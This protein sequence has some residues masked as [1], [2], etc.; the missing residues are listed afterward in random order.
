MDWPNIRSIGFIACPDSFCSGKHIK[1]NHRNTKKPW[2]K[3]RKLWAWFS[4]SPGL[5]SVGWECRTSAG[6]HFTHA[7]QSRK[8]ADCRKPFCSGLG[9]NQCWLTAKHTAAPQLSCRPK[10]NKEPIKQISL[11]GRNLTVAQRY[12]IFFYITFI[13]VN[14]RFQQY[15]RK[16]NH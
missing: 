5:S 3:N 9:G 12:F 2:L 14:K 7:A 11:R 16:N 6:S 8:A 13:Y 4:W 10:Q 1:W 15:L